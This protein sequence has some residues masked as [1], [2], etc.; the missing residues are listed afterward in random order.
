LPIRAGGIVR[1]ATLSLTESLLDAK[2]AGAAEAPPLTSSRIALDDA[3]V[4][5]ILRVCDLACQRSGLRFCAARESRSR[6]HQAVRLDRG[7]LCPV[8]NPESGS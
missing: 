8:L 1:A 3:S 2:S 7:H 5:R 4:E 6:F